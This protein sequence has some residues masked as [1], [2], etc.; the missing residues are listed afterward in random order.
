[1]EKKDKMTCTEMY[2]ALRRFLEKSKA[3]VLLEL[4]SDAIRAIGI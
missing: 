1:M 2:T 3:S 4:V